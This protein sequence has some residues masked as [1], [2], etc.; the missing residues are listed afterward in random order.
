MWRDRQDRAAALDHPSLALPLPNGNVLVDDDYNDQVV[1]I[2][3]KT[4][5]T[6][7]STVT[8]ASPAAR[9]ATWTTPTASTSR[10]RTRC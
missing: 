4:N 7:G 9:Q 2:G 3:P 1:V 6:D 8:T 10:R 5:R